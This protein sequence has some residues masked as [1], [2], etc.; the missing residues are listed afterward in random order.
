MTSEIDSTSPRL[1]ARLVGLFS[2]LTILCAIFSQ[3]F[4]S[5]R[6]IDFGSSSV[7]A[8]NILANRGVFQLGFTVYLIEMTCQILSAVLFY[9][10]LRPVNRTIAQL[11]LVFELVGCTVK[12]V[13]R[14]I[15]LAPLFV[16]ARPAGFKGLTVEQ[17][18]S[19]ALVLLRVN[20]LGAG[21]AVAFFGLSGLLGGYLV[22]RS[23]FLPRWLGIISMVAGVGWLTFAYPSFGYRAIPFAAGFGLLGS[24]ATIFWLLVVGVKEERW[25]GRAR[26]ESAP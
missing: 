3:G 18:E 8:K 26:L 19:V 7:T 21:V 17:L 20:D 12:I 11:A 25:R 15:Y 16:L 5:E 4:V 10:L 1:L 24:A 22:F 2:L 13:S 14:I 6:L 9:R 23:R